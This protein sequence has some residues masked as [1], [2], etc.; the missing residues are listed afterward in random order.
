MTDLTTRRGRRRDPAVDRAALQATLEI[1]SEQGYS[2]LRVGDVAARAGIGL[3]ALYRRWS[4]KRELVI[5]AVRQLAADQPPPPPARTP[6]EDL[7]AALRSINDALTGPDA[8]MIASLLAEPDTELAAVIREAKIE[9]VLDA[10]R[11][12]LRCVLGDVPDLDMR[13][14]LGPALLTF[15]ALVLAERTTIRQIRDDLVPL[16]LA[17]PATAP[18]APSSSAATR[19]RR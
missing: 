6:H 12:R 4:T 15:R 3:G 7:V 8:R 19:R 9:P 18:V 5:A 16:M 1:L 11:E 10:L 17:E 13:A 14:D 2:G